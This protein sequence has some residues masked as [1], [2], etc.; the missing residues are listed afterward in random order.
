MNHLLKVF[1]LELIRLQ[2]SRS[3]AEPTSLK[4]TSR[5]NLTT[6]VPA[7][8]YMDLHYAE[9]IKAGDLARRCGL[10]EAQFRRVFAANI[11]MTPMDYLNLIRVQN[12][13]KLMRRKN[14]SMEMIA[15]ECGF[16]SVS[17]FNRNF[18]KYLNTTPYQWKTNPD[19]FHSRIL[20]YHISVQKGWDS[21]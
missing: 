2:S 14:S 8:R 6:I 11:D 12:A 10:S 4:Q 9:S 15:A 17:T 21:L 19:N 7:L 1:L 20:D 16:P 5:G 18:R 13:C 3:A